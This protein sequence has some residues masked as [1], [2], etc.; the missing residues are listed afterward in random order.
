MFYPIGHRLP[1]SQQA[2]HQPIPSPHAGPALK[3]VAPHEQTYLVTGSAGYLGR[4]VVKGLLALPVRHVH[5]ICLPGSQRQPKEKRSFHSI[6]MDLM[7]ASLPSVFEDVQPDI[8][9]HCV[10]L[11][12]DAPLKDQLNVNVEGTRHLLQSIVDAQLSCRVIIIG[13]ASE[14]GPYPKPV[15]E[16]TIPHPVTDYGVSKYSQSLVAQLFAKK[17]NIPVIIARLFNP[18][19]ESPERF[20][21]ASLASQLAKAEVELEY[22]PECQP[23]IQAHSLDAF[24]DFIHIDDVVSGIIALAE[25]GYPGEIYNLA[26]GQAVPLRLIME[27]LLNH[28]PM[29]KSQLEIQVKPNGTPEFSQGTIQKIIAHTGWRPKVTLEQGLN[30][31]LAYWREHTDLLPIGNA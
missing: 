4:N 24:R 19:G 11:D 23:L 18:Y 30:E 26:S 17:Y 27:G 8:I 20:V 31:E 22:N 10:G 12:Q 2:N 13:S 5:G 14:Y 28:S 9:V 16:N 3:H 21:I 1:L 7:D 6:E 29:K 15:D 25:K